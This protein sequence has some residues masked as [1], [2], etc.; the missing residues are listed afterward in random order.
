MF[1]KIFVAFCLSLGVFF[2]GQSAGV[3][4]TET[5]CAQDV[6]CYGYVNEDNH[7]FDYYLQTETIKDVAEESKFKV[8]VVAD[9]KLFNSFIYRINQPN[10]TIMRMNGTGWTSP[11]SVYSSAMFTA[12]YNTVLQYPPA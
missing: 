2:A 12:I 8:K 1:K 5:A 7:R 4:E 6:W 9:G 3:I 10:K 11:V